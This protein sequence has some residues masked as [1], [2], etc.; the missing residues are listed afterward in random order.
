MNTMPMPIHEEHLPPQ[1][2]M[3]SSPPT[4]TEF[5]CNSQEQERFLPDDGHE[6]S[7]VLDLRPGRTLNSCKRYFAAPEP[8]GLFVRLVRGDDNSTRRNVTE[9]CPISIVSNRPWH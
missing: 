9:F 2:Q 6:S 5:L 1:I 3:Q 7:I 4:K 8:S